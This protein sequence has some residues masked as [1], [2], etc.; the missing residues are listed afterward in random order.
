MRPPPAPAP[1]PPLQKLD[2]NPASPQLFLVTASLVQAGLV[3]LPPLLR[4]LQPSDEDM[5]KAQE[6]ATLVLKQEVN[7]IGQ[8]SLAPSAEVRQLRW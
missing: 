8:V 6:A 4:Y 1:A 2:A 3:A 5:R 7:K